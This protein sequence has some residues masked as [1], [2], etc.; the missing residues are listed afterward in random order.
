M[1][2]GEMLLKLG[3]LKEAS[4]V[5]RELI[6]RNAENWLYYEGLERAVQ[7]RKQSFCKL[8]EQWFFVFDVGVSDLFIAL[9]ALVLRV[10]L[11]LPCAPVLSS[12]FWL[13]HLWGVWDVALSVRE[14][15]SHQALHTQSRNHF[16]SSAIFV[17]EIPNY[18]FLKNHQRLC[19][20][21]CVRFLDRM[22]C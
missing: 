7:P 15:G 6:D 20:A 9:E 18:K 14:E 12:H 8:L 5:Y 17:H 21:S 11:S 10:C 3:R 19:A 16:S 22:S 2:L 4:E 13:Q 1:A